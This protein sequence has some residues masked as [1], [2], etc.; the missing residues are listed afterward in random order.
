MTCGLWFPPASAWR[1]S[2]PRYIPRNTF[3]TRAPGYSCCRILRRRFSMCVLSMGGAYADMASPA[4][5]PALSPPLATWSSAPATRGAAWA[6]SGVSRPP[7]VKDRLRPSLDRLMVGEQGDVWRVC[8]TWDG[9]EDVRPR[10]S[11]I[12]AQGAAIAFEQYE[13]ERQFGVESACGGHLN[14]F[15]YSLR[16][17][18]TCREFALSVKDEAG[19]AAPG[20]CSCDESFWRFREHESWEHMRDAR[21]DDRRYAAWF[22]EHRAHRGDLEVQR[23]HRFDR[24]PL[25]SIVVPCFRSNGRFLSELIESVVSQSYRAWSSS[26]WTRLPPTAWSRLVRWRRGMS[27][28]AWSR[29]PGTRVSWATRTWALTPPGGITSPSSIM[30]IF[31]SQMPCFGTRVRSCGI[32]HVRRRSCTATKTCSRSRAHGVNPFSR[33]ASTWICSTAIT[34]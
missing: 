19:L 13:F 20:F 3:T 22:E 14:R 4:P 12:D 26:S 29:S 28:S 30:T 10:L 15:F 27:E 2:L 34:V 1:K 21:A 32:P 33:R 18:C 16:L 8:V 6:S 23:A 9:A 11:I 25:F 5:V 24:E 17:P 7:G 31:S